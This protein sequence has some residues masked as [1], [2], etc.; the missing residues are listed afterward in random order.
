[1][2]YP[3]RIVSITKSVIE[4]IVDEYRN[5]V[6]TTK[7][8][9]RQLEAEGVSK[10]KIKEAGRSVE[11]QER[12]KKNRKAYNDARFARRQKRKQEE[13]GRHLDEIKS[14]DPNTTCYPAQAFTGKDNSGNITGDGPGSDRSSG[15]NYHVHRSTASDEIMPSQ[16]HIGNKD[17]RMDEPL[18]REETG[19]Q[20]MALTIVDETTSLE[21]NLG[22]TPEQDPTSTTGHVRQST[23][24][25]LKQDGGPS[26]ANEMRRTDR[27]T[28]HEHIIS[29]ITHEESH[30]ERKAMDSTAA[31]TGCGSTHEGGASHEESTLQKETRIRLTT[32]AATKSITINAVPLNTQHISEVVAMAR[33][34]GYNILPGIEDTILDLD[35]NGRH[36]N[37][38]I[39]TKK[40]Q[41][42]PSQQ[43]GSPHSTSDNSETFGCC[44]PNKMDDSKP[45]PILADTY[46]MVAVHL[47]QW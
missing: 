4:K 40:D 29:D 42:A 35:E 36:K 17:F 14:K 12:R 21:D 5:T 38:M 28:P 7:E 1:M 27:G 33:R 10:S 20:L 6:I 23:R 13:E 3:E 34:D 43:E 45:S 46:P 24:R 19:T 9:L 8:Y 32:T 18:D 22:I 16:E 39:A 11:A 26:T 31:S 25:R 37:G 15:K 41:T 47:P 2:E 44:L 30:E